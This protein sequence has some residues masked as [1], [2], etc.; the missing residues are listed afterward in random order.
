MNNYQE[1]PK[2]SSH[3]LIN[4]GPVVWVSTRDN[5]GAYDIAPIAWGCPVRKDPPK[6]AVVVGNRHK[7]HENIK[8]TG[9]FI[10]CVPHATQIELVKKT[11]SKS[12]MDLNKFEAFGIRA[13]QGKKVDAL[14]PEGCIG[15]LECRVYSSVEVE[16]VEMFIGEVLSANVNPEAYSGRLLTE[17][18][19]GK[20]L[21]HLGE[22]I[23]AVPSDAVLEAKSS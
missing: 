18:E 5:K 2:D 13:F 8:A 17:K 23:F 11:G 14:I 12:G 10:V 19:E 6:L 3:R 7:T 21:H 1:I 9:E 20:T 22:R 4:H 16:K 15:Y